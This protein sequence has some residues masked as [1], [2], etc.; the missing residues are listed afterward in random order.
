MPLTEHL[1]DQAELLEFANDAI[2]LTDA[3]GTITYW[4]RG[5]TPN[6]RLG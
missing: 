5:S 4:N 3:H 1:M 2:I 6:L